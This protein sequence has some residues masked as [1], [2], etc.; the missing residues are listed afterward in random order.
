[1]TEKVLE[2]RR[3]HD[4]TLLMTLKFFFRN[5]FLEHSLMVKDLINPGSRVWRE[6]L[7]ISGHKKKFGGSHLVLLLSRMNWCGT[8]RR[9]TFL[10]RN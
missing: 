5:M 9:V 8:M 2:Y 3:M 4:F 1:M 10:R 7:F 6:D